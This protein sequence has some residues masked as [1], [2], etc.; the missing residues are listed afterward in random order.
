MPKTRILDA[1]LKFAGAEPKYNSELTKIDMIRALNWY[2]EN[3]NDKDAYKYA[4][5]YLK[6]NYK[7]EAMEQIK[8]M[9]PTFGW[10]CRIISNGGKLSEK[11]KTWLEA[12][13]ATIKSKI[14][15]KKRVEKQAVT[16]KAEKPSIQDRLSEKV[17]EIAGEI[18][19]S[20]DDYILSNY[21]I[22][23]SPLALM[24]EKAK[25][26][27]ANRLIEI[28]RKKRVEFDDVL[29]TKDDQIK[30]GY[31]N[32]SKAELKK[33]IAYC[34]LIITDAMKLIGEV[35]KTRK[36]RKR[37]VKTAEQIIGKLKYLVESKTLKVKSVDP[38]EIIG[39]TQLWIYNEKTRKL[40]C[41][42]AEDASGFGVKGTT[43][44][45]FNETKSVQKKLRKP[46]VMVPEVLNGGKVFLRN[47]IGNIRAV[48]SP[49]N[50][51]LNKDTILL[52][53]IK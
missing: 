17:N 24:Q 48:E 3:K 45:N 39:S 14:A 29:N 19:G 38:K 7:I 20:I 51:R 41:Y 18:E 31:S 12:Q 28:F 47:V 53:V 25:G 1:N 36:P 32:F 26:M 52:R 40:G 37:K 42:H 46:E 43:I 34:D 50:G 9:A 6:K 4:H 30:E 5:D 22:L 8:D 15:T 11:E 21:K 16:Q 27:H 44:L 33:L 23:P 10:V 49:L 2:N 35:K 13:I